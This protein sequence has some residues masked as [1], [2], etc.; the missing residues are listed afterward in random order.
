MRS[1]NFCS[2]NSGKDGRS[3][4]C[5]GVKSERCTFPENRR[6][7]FGVGLPLGA[8]LR[9]ER[10]WMRRRGGRR[11]SGCNQHLGV[12]LGPFSASLNFSSRQAAMLRCCAAAATPT[13][14]LPLCSRW[15]R[16]PCRRLQPPTGPPVSSVGGSARIF[17]PVG[18]HG[19]HCHHY[20]HHAPP[21]ARSPRLCSE[22][23]LTKFPHKYAQHTA[24][25]TTDLHAQPTLL[26]SPLALVSRL[27][28]PYRRRPSARTVSIRRR[29]QLRLCSSAARCPTSCR[30]KRCG[31]S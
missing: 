13:P 20:H 9:G 17:I 27:Q 23:P 5:R 24:R 16:R 3:N 8:R 31:G 14:T 6:A 2:R 28:I 26:S 19:Q 21:I 7:F 15:R 10:A 22:R 12:S 18:C 1:D 30:S 29:V 25:I 11:S 4:L